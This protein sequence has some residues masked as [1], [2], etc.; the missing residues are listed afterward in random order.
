VTLLR[1]LLLLTLIGPSAAAASLCCDE[2]FESECS[3]PIG[4]CPTGPA[5]ECLMSVAAAPVVSAVA[6]SLETPASVRVALEPAP[7]GLGPVLRPGSAP[8]APA[9]LYLA[10]GNLR[11]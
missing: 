1:V 5:G 11:N 4:A 6:H 10:F 7:P 2:S 9:P 8:M 3:D